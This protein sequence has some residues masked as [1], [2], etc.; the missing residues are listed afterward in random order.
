[1]AIDSPFY[2]GYGLS[3]YKYTV[4]YRIYNLK[5]CSGLEVYSTTTALETRL[6]KGSKG[7]IFREE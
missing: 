6:L 7:M 1:M 2:E 4:K 5:C 3:S